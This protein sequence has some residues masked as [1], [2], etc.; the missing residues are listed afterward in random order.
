MDCGRGVTML[1]VNILL[2]NYEDENVK[3]VEC[4]IDEII[5][6]EKFSYSASVSDNTIID[7]V[8]II[9]AERG[10]KWE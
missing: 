9:L 5:I 2:K 3:E 7:E 4:I 8:L 6:K 1:T 10:Y